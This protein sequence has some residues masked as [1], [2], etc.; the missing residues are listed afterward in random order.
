MEH[1]DPPPLPR[2]KKVLG[3]PIWAF[4]L[5]CATPV[6]LLCCVGVISFLATRPSTVDGVGGEATVDAGNG[7]GITNDFN[8]NPIDGEK[9]WL[10][11]R[12]RIRTIITRIGRDNGGPYAVLMC[13]ATV[14]FASSDALASLR[15]D[16]EVEIETTITNYTPKER[17]SM[18][19]F[20]GK[21]TV[22]VATLGRMK[23]N[24]N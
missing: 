8:A 19:Q 17:L 13:N 6:P 24:P 11:K 2:R 15:E 16:D 23:R 10:N 7:N 9:K 18:A 3:L 5:L 4:V 21:K 22:L 20:Q 12:V 1:D 14:Y